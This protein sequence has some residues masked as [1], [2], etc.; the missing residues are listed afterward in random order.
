MFNTVLILFFFFGKTDMAVML[1]TFSVCFAR[2]VGPEHIWEEM[3]SYRVVTTSRDIHE[4]T[5]EVVIYNNVPEQT[6]W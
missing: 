3:E 1:L 2:M 6:A 4:L 5:L